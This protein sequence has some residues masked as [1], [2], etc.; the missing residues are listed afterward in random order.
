MLQIIFPFRR[1]GIASTGNDTTERARGSVIQNGDQ[2]RG[3]YEIAGGM[4]ERRTRLDGCRCGCPGRGGTKRF[5]DSTRG[6]WMSSINVA[7]K[8]LK[9][10]GKRCSRRAGQA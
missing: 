4:Q 9:A 8:G 5:G 7:R 6:G 1:I 10:A 3:Q 2:E